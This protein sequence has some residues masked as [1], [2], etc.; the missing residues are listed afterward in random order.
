MTSRILRPVVDIAMTLLLL[1]SMAYE[2]VG[3]AFAELCEKLFGM[4]FDGYEYGALMNEAIGTAFLL[5]IAFHLWLNRR[6]LMNMF[7][8]RYNAARSVLVLADILLIVDVVFL[9]VSGVMMSRALDLYVDDGMSFARTAHLL[10]SYW[11]YV[12]MSFHIGLHFRKFPLWL[13]APMAYGVYAF[14]QRQIG[15]YM[16]LY[17]E[18]VFF[19]FD[20]PIGYFFLDYIAVMLLFSGVGCAVMLLCRKWVK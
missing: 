20:E 15:E 16:F 8:G 7:K 14:I 13:L 1:L 6:W 9:T 2:L 3:P 12:I 17:S 18:F 5:L 4:S 11:G 10:S 19:D